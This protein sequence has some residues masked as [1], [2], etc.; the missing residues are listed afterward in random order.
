MSMSTHKDR[1]EQIREILRA[2]T[3][4]PEVASRYPNLTR[5]V[6]ALREALFFIQQELDWHMRQEADAYRD[7]KFDWLALLA[8]DAG[9]NEE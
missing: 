8:L 4:S 1:G 7:E 2:M 6:N 3:E 5:R 9:R